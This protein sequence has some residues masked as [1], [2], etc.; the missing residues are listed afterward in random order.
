MADRSAA[1]EDQYASKLAD[2]GVDIK[3][4]VQIALELKENCDQFSGPH[5]HQQ[6]YFKFLDKLLPVFIQI[7]EDKPPVPIPQN[8]EVRMFS[9]FPMEQNRRKN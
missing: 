7:L 1:R 5:A 9:R 2:P 4:K 3:L 6:S 8:E